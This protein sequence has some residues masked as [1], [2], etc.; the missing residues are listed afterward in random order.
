MFGFPFQIVGLLARYS[1]F[2]M[3]QIS[4]N[5]I[6]LCKSLYVEVTQEVVCLSES[7]QGFEICDDICALP[8]F[9][10]LFWWR[11]L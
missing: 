5:T 6:L 3:K 8:Y 10:K 11:A 9:G 2:F 7:H 1:V 4:T